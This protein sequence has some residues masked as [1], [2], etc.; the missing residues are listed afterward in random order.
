LTKRESGWWH[1]FYTAFRPFFGL[2]SQKETNA[3]ARFI[4]KKLDL[5]PGRKFLDCPCGIGR[6]SL[7]VAKKGIGVTGVDIIPSYLDEVSIKAK[8][9]G[10]KINLVHSDMRRI[11]FDSKFDAVGNLW[12]SFGFFR[13]ES[14][15]RLVVKKMYRALKPGGKFV[16]H[17]INR[18]WIIANFRPRDWYEAGGVKSTE[19]RY[20]DYRT[21]VNHGLWRF[22]KDGE[23]K[24][25]E[26]PIRLYSLHELIAI[27]RSAGFIN[28]ESFG[29]VKD[30]PVT[31]DSRMIYVIGTKPR[32]K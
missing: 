26:S 8:R 28:I 20:I 30:E 19:E 24:T 23:E 1:D 5:K 7:P 21:S 22:I 16:L 18:D 31:R 32:R 25:I 10:L 2:I 4:I 6:I 3:Q 12:T 13:K 27:F 17:V 29:S 9:R 14:D 15:N 11:N